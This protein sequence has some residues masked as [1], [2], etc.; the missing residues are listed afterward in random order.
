L[1]GEKGAHKI[2]KLILKKKKKIKSWGKEG[3]G[4]QKKKQKT[5]LFGRKETGNGNDQKRR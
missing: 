2:P 4:A 1:K 3:K 5:D